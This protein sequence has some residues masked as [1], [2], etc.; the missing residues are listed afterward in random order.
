MNKKIFLYMFLIVTSI[1]CVQSVSAANISVHPGDSIQSAVDKASNGDTV[2]VYGD[3][4]TSSTYK[5]SVYINKKVNIKSSGNVIIEAKNTSSAVFTVN[6][7]GSGSSIQNFDLTKSNYCIV[8]NNAQNCLIS[9]NKII[10]A[11]LVGIQFYG[12]M[13]NSKVLYNQIT[14]TDPAVG[15][16]ISFEYGLCSYN[17]VSG[18]IISNF[19]NGILF[20]DESEYNSVEGNTVTCNGLNGAGIY[21]TDN[22]RYLRIVGN[23]VSGAEDGIAVQ[24]IGTNT[25]TNYLLNGNTVTGNKNGF[26][27]RLDDSTISNNIA[28]Y[29]A[30]SGIDITG[31]CN[32][33]LD[34]TASYNGNC[35]ITL[36]GICDNNYNL[37]N[38]NILS[39]NQAGLNSASQN[40][41]YSNNE[42]SYNS[43]NGMIVTADHSSIIC[44]Q[45][46]NN[47][48]S[49]VLCIG[50]FNL[51]KSNQIS[52]NN[53]GIY[54]Q[55]ASTA[56]NNVVSYNNITCNK[57][58]INSA[59]PYTQFDHN[60]I[61]GNIE[62]GFINTA[63][64]VSICSNVI[65][66][67]KYC[68]ILSIGIYNSLTSNSI[69]GNDLGICLQSASDADHNNIN[70]NNVCYNNNGINSGISYS[71]FSCNTLNYNYG[72]GLTATGSWCVINGNSM[73]NNT[74]AGLTITGN[75]NNVYQNLIYNNLY[76]AS[77]SS[78]LAA[79]F[80]FNSVVGNTYQLYQ[81][82]NEGLLLN[83]QFNWW[84]SNLKPQKI[85]GAINYSRWLILKLT[86]AKSQI[87]G[88]SS[89]VIADLN[90]DSNGADVSKLGHVKN[91]FAICFCSTLGTISSNIKTV[92]GTATTWFKAVNPGYAKISTVLDSQKTP[93]SVSVY[94]AVRSVNLS[95][96]AINVSNK[97][98]IQLTYRMPIKFGK[99][100][101]IELK[102]SKGRSVSIK[103]KIKSNV[104]TISHATLAKGT[105]YIL[106]IHTGTIRDL[107]N[108]SM[109]AYNLKFT[110]AK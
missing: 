88:T 15:N 86:T 13:S 14:G 25:A 104:L 97:K 98:I 90:H 63:D 22:S 31:K 51:I 69:S 28:I 99:K 42:V 20:N 29:N 79:V 5:E 26:W 89:C 44:N 19:L 11:S 74:D 45:I 12:D 59:S 17:N 33:I 46:S 1:V 49:G 94:S 106:V 27:I 58:G 102:T 32:K 23:T 70:S 81:P 56:D 61:N 84:G 83:A 73:K 65:N 8:I 103:P 54:L 109:P 82:S 75:Y 67:N 2:V 50:L 41:I 64:H 55:N 6:S 37:V 95:N 16:G 77:F 57:N 21:A 62:N 36:T 30:V 34:N 72:T 47:G 35:G 87:A 91:G 78:A 3:N 107:K 43:N 71:N 96:N 105:K 53:L 80:N 40:T 60:N 110:T 66:N 9:G 4:K 108:N 18:N 38:G 85:Y 68:G 92:N 100:I 24:Q 10:G 101:T 39:H 93:R 7:E 76:G 52:G 48:G